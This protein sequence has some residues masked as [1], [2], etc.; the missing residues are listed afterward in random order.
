LDLNAKQKA[1]SRDADREANVAYASCMA[2]GTSVAM[3]L[4]VAELLAYLSGA[5][6][7]YVP[8]RD[9]PALWGMPMKEF[10]ATARVPS[11]WGWIALVGRGDYVNFIGIALLA[12]VT[13]ACYLL[14]L[15]RFLARRDRIYAAMAA[16]QILVLLAAASGLISPAR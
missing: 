4:I 1:A 7:P 13:I 14:A 2:K 11:G 8:L 6:S 5:L 12:S 16:A 10:L 15:R 9:L 3:A